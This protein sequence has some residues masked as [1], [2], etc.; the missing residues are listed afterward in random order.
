MPEL[1][2]F[3]ERVF[4]KTKHLYEQLNLI[5]THV[6]SNGNPTANTEELKKR[7][8]RQDKLNRI[9]EEAIR[10]AARA[11]NSPPQGI[12]TLSSGNTFECTES[13]CENT[14]GYLYWSEL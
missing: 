4:T 11:F 7:I 10:K 13:T 6:E 1:D 9:L 3:G 8:I 5:K 2:D 12:C 14:A